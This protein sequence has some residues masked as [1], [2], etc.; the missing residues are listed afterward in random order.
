MGRAGGKSGDGG[1]LS[2]E[3]IFRPSV[4]F[5]IEAVMCFDQLSGNL[6]WF[7]GGLVVMADFPAQIIRGFPIQGFRK[8]Q[9]PAIERFTEN[10]AVKEGLDVG[11]CEGES[12]LGD[13]GMVE[14][15]HPGKHAGHAVGKFSGEAGGDVIREIE[16]P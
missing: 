4:E 14:I 5:A 12:L 7:A 13:G 8:Q 11:F 2:L 15:R 10:D 6:V 9:D 3:A 1:R 16:F